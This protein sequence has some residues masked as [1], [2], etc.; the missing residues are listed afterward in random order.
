MTGIMESSNPK[1]EPDRIYC[2]VR[3]V[4]V[5]AL[6]EERIRQ[7]WLRHMICELL[8]PLSG[9][10]VEK[11]LRQ[12]PHLLLT[13]QKLPD[14]RV[15]LV[16]F[17]KGN[18][19]PLLLV[20]CKAVKLTSAVINQVLGYNHYLGARFIA[21]VNGEEVRLGWHEDVSK[22]YRFISRLPSYQE[23]TAGFAV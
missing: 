10:A 13:R 19:R 23:L 6:P 12:M 11:A 14:R 7:Q 15:D 2:P 1:L 8:F 20:E 16:Y 22:Q 17:D 3:K 4:W 5:A 18:S 9:F 21:V